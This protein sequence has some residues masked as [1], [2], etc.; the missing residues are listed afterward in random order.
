MAGLRDA[1]TIS[2]EKEAAER[3]DIVSGS[4]GSD[5]CVVPPLI[6]DRNDY[7]EVEDG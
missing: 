7:A 6:L 2:A 4:S 1:G 5:F 3:I